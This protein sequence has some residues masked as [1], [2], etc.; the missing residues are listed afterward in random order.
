[1]QMFIIYPKQTVL[2][3]ENLISLLYL[4]T[5]VL[6]NYKIK[7]KK[8]IGLYIKCLCMFC[9]GDYSLTVMVMVFPLGSSN[10]SMVVMLAII[11]IP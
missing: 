9:F 4:F 11:V 1:M 3:L 8:S 10:L 6:L 7:Y 2:T 5:T